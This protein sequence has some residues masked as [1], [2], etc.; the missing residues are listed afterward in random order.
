MDGAQAT[1]KTT[2]INS[3]PGCDQSAT[4]R[5]VAY[6]DK[7]KQLKSSQRRVR[8]TIHGVS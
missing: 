5:I 8:T 1:N 3:D 4:L 6:S 7:I 2:D